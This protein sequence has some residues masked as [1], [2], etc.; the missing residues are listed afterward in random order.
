MPQGKLAQPASLDLEN[1][2]KNNQPRVRTRTTRH[3]G[4]RVSSPGTSGLLFRRINRRDH[5]YLR[6]TLEILA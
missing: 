2:L 4:C 5:N 6:V 3:L 1:E